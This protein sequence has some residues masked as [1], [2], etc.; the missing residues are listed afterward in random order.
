M[1]SQHNA[2]NEFAHTHTHTLTTHRVHI[3][4]AITAQMRVHNYSEITETCPESFYPSSL[5]SDRVS[6]S[7]RVIPVFANARASRVV[8]VYR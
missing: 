5:H 4:G 1:A 7:A 8:F 2:G 6:V 3:A